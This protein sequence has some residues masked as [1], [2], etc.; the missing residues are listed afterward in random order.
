ML[1]PQQLVTIGELLDA[2]EGEEIQIKFK[3]PSVIFFSFYSGE[4]HIG[5]WMYEILPDGTKRVLKSEMR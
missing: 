4:Y 5:Q 3:R 2:H 1:T